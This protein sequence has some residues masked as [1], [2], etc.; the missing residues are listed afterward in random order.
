[1]LH[2]GQKMLGLGVT[3]ADGTKVVSSPQQPSRLSQRLALGVKRVTFGETLSDFVHD[4][5][6]PTLSDLGEVDW[7]IIVRKVNDY[8]KHLT[9]EKTYNKLFT[10]FSNQ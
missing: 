9:G 4:P 7:V 8:V 5:H 3:I 2:G 6:E 10:H 1:M